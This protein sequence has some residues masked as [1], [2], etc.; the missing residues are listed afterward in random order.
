MEL[1][2]ANRV[3]KAK[4]NVIPH[5]LSALPYDIHAATVL[6][7]AT[8]DIEVGEELLYSYGAPYWSDDYSQ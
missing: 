1:V 7:R 2:V 6:M 3:S 5:I 4:E 8:R